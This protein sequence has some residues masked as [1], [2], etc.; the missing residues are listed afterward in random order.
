MDAPPRKA[1][2][3]AGVNMK[4]VN[5]RRKKVSVRISE[6]LQELHDALATGRPLEEFFT[7]RT[8]EIPDPPAFTAKKV[9]ALRKRMAVSQAIFASL[10]G[11]SAEL[12]EHWEQ[13]VRVPQR[14][15]CRL[16]AEIQRDPADFLKRHLKHHTKR[17][18]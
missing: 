10:L 13:G 2:E 9:R 16:L 4:Q 18:A 17:V 15:A 1:F 7:V 12:V 3:A 8:V 6:S 14:I 11:V 5:N